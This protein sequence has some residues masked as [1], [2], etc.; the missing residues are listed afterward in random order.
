[1]VGTKRIHQYYHEFDLRPGGVWRLTMHGPDGADYENH[2]EF[3]EV[4]PTQK[5]SFRHSGAMHHFIMTIRFETVDDHHALMEWLMDFDKEDINPSFKEFILNA[6][7][8]NFDRLEALL[9]HGE[10]ASN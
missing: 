10:F 9:A 5:I 3:I 2:K 8:D 6:N 7:E 4:L 1:M